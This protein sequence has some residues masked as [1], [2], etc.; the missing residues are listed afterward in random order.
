[1]NGQDIHPSAEESSYR[2][3]RTIR[4]NPIF[5]KETRGL[6][7]QQR[8]RSVFTFYLFFLAVITFLL[9]VTIISANT[10]SP[11]PDV[12]RTMGKIIF[13]ATTL[14]QFV[15]VLFIAPLFCA[16]AVTVE[17]EH[18]TFDLLRITFMHTRSIIRGKLL[19]GFVYAFLFLLISLPLQSSMFLLGG[20]TPPEFLVSILLL[21]STTIFL[22]SVSIWASTRSRRTS[23][24]IGLAY[25]I[26]S[27][28]LVGFPALVYVM[29]KL[30]PFPSDQAFFDTLHSLSKN[31]APIP[32]AILIIV[33]WLLISTNPIS[34]AII[35]Y[36]LFRDEGLRVL[37]DLNAYQIC[38]PFLAP[39]IT[40]TLFYLLTSW[41]FYRSAVRRIRRSSKL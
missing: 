8:F 9:Y 16:D 32:Q 26:S 12:R 3:K 33:V 34:T 13:L 36:N 23:S 2:P 19:A 15:A 4:H 39:W 40:F 1:M 38:V 27:A 25:I 10:V 18:S 21:V 20:V 28:I 35:S 5:V 29:M 7:R 31:L 30:A 11:D 41:L 6:I 24:A 14:A 22:C 37:Y 17:R